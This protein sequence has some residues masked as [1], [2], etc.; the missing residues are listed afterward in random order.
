MQDSGRR[1][2]P[3]SI[4]VSSARAWDAVS[5]ALPD[6]NQFRD[7]LAFSPRFAPPRRVAGR[8]RV[9]IAHG[10]PEAGLPGQR[11]QE[12]ARHRAAAGY[13]VEFQQFDG[14]HTVPP[15]VAIGALGRLG[16]AAPLSEGAT[17]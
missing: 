9:F 15:Q 5:A 17:A 4:G 6:G 7:M 14:A 12:I 8:P 11:G 3:R 10:A 13:D 1:P 16:G 2:R